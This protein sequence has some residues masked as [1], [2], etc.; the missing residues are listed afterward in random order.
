MEDVRGWPKH[1]YL[2]TLESDYD[3][4]DLDLRAIGVVISRPEDSGYLKMSLFLY[5]GLVRDKIM[6]TREVLHIHH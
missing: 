6:L 3:G 5:S 1:Y 2:G 4:N